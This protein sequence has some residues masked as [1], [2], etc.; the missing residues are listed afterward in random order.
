MKFAFSKFDHLKTMLKC[1]DYEQ[2]ELNR[3]QVNFMAWYD[4]G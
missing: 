4:R 2:Y 3:I 1:L